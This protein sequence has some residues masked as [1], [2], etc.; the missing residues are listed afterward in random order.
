MTGVILDPL[1]HL[2]NRVSQ[3]LQEKKGQRGTQ[4]LL[5]PLVKMVHPGQED[6]LETEAFLDLWELMD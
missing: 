4:A 6:F 3:E 5:V 2:E 1:D